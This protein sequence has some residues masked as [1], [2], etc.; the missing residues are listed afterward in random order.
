MSASVCVCVRAKIHYLCEQVDWQASVLKECR[1]IVTLA[2]GLAGAAEL[3]GCE[4]PTYSSHHVIMLLDG[5]S[6]RECQ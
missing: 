2:D 3:I 1:R 6:I 5:V 4:L